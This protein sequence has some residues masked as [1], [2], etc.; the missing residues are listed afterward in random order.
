MVP[1]GKVALHVPVRPAATLVQSIPAG[2]EVTVP[3][4]GP[5]A[6]VTSSQKSAPV[7]VAIALRA[8][9]MLTVQPPVP[10]QAPDQPLNECPL[11]AVAVSVT[12]VPSVKLAL[13]VPLVLP[14][15]IEQLI[16]LGLD[17]TE[18]FPVPLPPTVS[19]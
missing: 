7:N 12:L 16:P 5:A 14:L 19:V 17:V 18:P 11:A 13:H 10:L 4:P 9:V 3:L 6:M 8:C 2:L 15:E 1:F